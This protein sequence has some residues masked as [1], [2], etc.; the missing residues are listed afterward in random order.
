[1]AAI[2]VKIYEN[3]QYKVESSHNGAFYTLIR[4]KDNK[5]CFFQGDSALIF[6]GEMI[7]AGTE[8]QFNN[9][10]SQYDEVMG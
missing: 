6:E 10:F 4:L 5:S 7:H 2:Q 3:T 9:V 8:E 1:M